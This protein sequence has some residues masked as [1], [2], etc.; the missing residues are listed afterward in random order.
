MSGTPHAHPKPGKSALPRIVHLDSGREMRGGQW[1]ALGL[2]EGL[3]ALGV[4]SLLL[5]PRGSPLEWAARERSMPVATLCLR[6]VWLESRRNTILHAHDA[7]SHTMAALSGARRLVVSRRVVFPPKQGLLSRWKYARAT[8]FLAV[9]A[10]VR[11]ELVRAGIPPERIRVVYDGVE[12]LPPPL[13]HCDIVALESGDPGKCNALARAAAAMGGFPV[14]FSRDLPKAF[15][16]AKL[17]LY[18]S[19]AEGLG[20]AAL[21]AM[22]AGIPVVVS[23]IPALA[24]VVEDGKTGLL[25]D[26]E[27]S[28]VAAAVNLLLR[29]G[30]LAGRLGQA[31]RASVEAHFRMDR[32][33]EN[34]LAAYQSL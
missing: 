33:V 32:M 8:L 21:L 27:A 23:R 3:L 4:D 6:R 12:P 26:N 28:A 19:R 25:V 1:Q 31:G 17:F 29:D 2:H 9:S 11:E 16:A 22:S 30:A 5:A 20:S 24:E 18:L 34:T 15:R 7:A 10:V 14:S 13:E